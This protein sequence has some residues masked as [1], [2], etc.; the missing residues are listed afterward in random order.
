MQPRRG[1][2]V[3]LAGVG[4]VLAVV[5]AVTGLWALWQTSRFG[6]DNWR[7]ITGAGSGVLFWGWMASGAWQRAIEPEADQYEPSPVPRRV[8]F[9]VANLV[10]AVLFTV[11]VGFGLWESVDSARN[12]ERLALVEHSVQLAAREA[13]LTVD[14]VRRLEAEWSLW[15]TSS[16]GAGTPDPV[17]EVLAVQGADVV[18]VD[19]G[20]KMASI[21]FRPADGPPCIVLDIDSD[22]L[23]STRQTRNCT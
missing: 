4:T 22:D 17:L 23:A 8:A 14:D 15:I 3:A 2:W 13:R 19:A 21:M 5:I 9:V 16:V 10:L 7:V 11:L 18:A 1:G 6:G 12:S 20:E